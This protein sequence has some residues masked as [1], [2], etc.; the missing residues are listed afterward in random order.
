VVGLALTAT[1]A[2]GAANNELRVLPASFVLAAHGGVGKVYAFQFAEV[3]TITGGTLTLDFSGISELATPSLPDQDLHCSLA[4]AKATC[5]L[6]DHHGSDWSAYRKV[7]VR[8]VPLAG[9]NDGATGTI[10]AVA[11]ADT[12]KDATAKADVTVKDGA[13]LVVLAKDDFGDLGTEHADVGDTVTF[14]FDFTNDGSAAAL[15]YAVTGRLKQGLSLGKADACTNTTKNGLVCRFPDDRVDPGRRATF[16]IPVHVD[17]DATVDESMT[18][19][20]D[21][22]KVAGGGSAEDIYRN[23]NFAN[24]TWDT[25]AITD[26][27]AIGATATGAPGDTVTITVGVQNVGPA[28][29]DHSTLGDDD[30]GIAR[31]VVTIP[32][33]AK[34]TDVACEQ[35]AEDPKTGHWVIAGDK[36]TLQVGER[37]V[38]KMTLKI[39]A[40][41]GTDGSVTVDTGYAAGTLDKTTTD[42]VARITLHSTANELPATGQ[43]SGLIVLVGAGVVLLGGLLVLASRRRT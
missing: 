24:K 14:E 40:T 12:A 21:T 20:V 37:D 42:N 3:G 23:D 34:V 15:G 41:H 32:S 6:P 35:C 5:V 27:K 38:V 9:A 26:L 39:V 33:W 19:T 31:F 22:I 18:V 17:A 29:I 16:S 13:D 10:D 4:A 2:H 43:H 28:W 7:Y 25:N 1:P 8:L 36:A 30:S 11:S